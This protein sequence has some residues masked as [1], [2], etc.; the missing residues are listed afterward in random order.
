M[1][2]W[3][4]LTDHERI[5]EWRRFRLSLEGLDDHQTI[6]S[7]AEY[8]KTVPISSRYIDYYTP[9]SWPSPWDI[10]SMGWSCESS[11]SLL[12]AH[13]LKL[14]GYD[15]EVFLVDSPLGEFLLPVINGL[16]LNYELG[17]AVDLQSQQDIIIKSKHNI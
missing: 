2:N 12:M 7:I 8:F 4:T 10:L 13:T 3:N 17:R 1:T 14:S 6:Q 5:L 16:L 11:I 9:E 15:C